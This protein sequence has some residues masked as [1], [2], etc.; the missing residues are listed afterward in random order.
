M[1]KKSIHRRIVFLSVYSQQGHRESSWSMVVYNT[2]QEAS[3]TTSPRDLTVVAA[4]GSITNVNINWQPPKTPN[5]QISGYIIA[6]TTDQTKP[7]RD[8]AVEAVVGDRLTCSI[9]GLKAD[10]TYYFRIQ[11]R[12]K[13]G[14]G[15][16]SSAYTF[17][18]PYSTWIINCVVLEINFS[19]SKQLLEDFLTDLE[20]QSALVELGKQTSCCWRLPLAWWSFYLFLQY[21]SLSAAENS[22]TTLRREIKKCKCIL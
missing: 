3:P 5:G 12:N 18:T 13:M 15:P 21:P 7:E 22:R 20:I 10:T 2:T 16:F 14:Y 11:A 1:R 6:Y 19:P 9:K 4:E 8:W 17:K